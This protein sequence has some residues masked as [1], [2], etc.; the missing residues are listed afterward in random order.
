[1]AKVHLDGRHL[2]KIQPKNEFLNFKKMSSG[3]V[4]TSD[5][6]NYTICSLP[7]SRETIPLRK[8]RIRFYLLNRFDT[9]AHIAG[10]L[11]PDLNPE[12]RTKP[13]QFI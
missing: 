8:N 12:A 1:M 6:S 13:P 9:W 10:R 4:R 2:K 7:Q 11:N 3:I 5:P